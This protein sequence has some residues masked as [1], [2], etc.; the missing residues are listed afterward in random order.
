MKVE[1]ESGLKGFRAQNVLVLTA[2]GGRTAKD[3]IDIISKIKCEFL[4]QDIK[5][6]EELKIIQHD[7]QIKLFIN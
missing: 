2:L 7:K 1:E 6:I 5:E 3:F 4:P